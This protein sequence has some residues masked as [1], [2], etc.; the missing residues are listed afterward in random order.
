VARMRIE[1]LENSF[2]RGGDKF[3]VIGLV[4]VVGTHDLQHLAEH[5]ELA[6]GLGAGRRGSARPD[7]AIA[8]VEAE[9]EQSGAGCRPDDNLAKPRHGDFPLWRWAG[10]EMRIY[11]SFRPISDLLI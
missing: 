10:C 2:D 3:F 1:R 5:F 6:A 8:W 11:P 7:L 4:D 9:R